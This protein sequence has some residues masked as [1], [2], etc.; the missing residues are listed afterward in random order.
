MD[1]LKAKAQMDDD[2]AQK[3][4]ELEELA[5][6]KEAMDRWPPYPSLWIAACAVPRLK[7]RVPSP[8]FQGW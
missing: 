5:K 2:V 1:E 7:A 3:R 6:Q 8:R 4:K